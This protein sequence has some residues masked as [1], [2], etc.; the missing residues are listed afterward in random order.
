MYDDLGKS[1]GS[2]ISSG[3][4]ARG[5]GY[6]RNAMQGLYK[7][8]EQKRQSLF[9]V[10]Y[11]SLALGSNLYDVYSQNKSAIDIGE[12]E[13][14]SVTSNWLT[15]L[16]GTPEFMKGGEIFSAAEVNANNLLGI[17]SNIS[18]STE[19]IRDI[20]SSFFNKEY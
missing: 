13:G 14:Y 1:L 20:P 19:K 11:Q 10:L 7:Y 4:Q 5:K 2:A 8:K 3:H 18:K 6:E 17:N 12:K 16:F 15:N 9:D